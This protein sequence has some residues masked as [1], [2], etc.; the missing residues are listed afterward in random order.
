MRRLSTDA[1]LAACRLSARRA[2]LAVVYHRLAARTGDP[3]SELVPAHGTALV[4][5][6]L[7]LV[8]RHFKLV[9]ASELL[10]AA[11]RR[12]RGGRF[13]LA[14]TFDDDLRSHV[15][16]ARPLLTRIGAPATFFV[17]GASLDGPHTFWWER[18]QLA[19]DRGQAHDVTRL[20]ER[21][22]ARLASRPVLTIH[23][24]ALA[25]DHL[26]PQARD[27]F[28]DDLAELTGPASAAAGL[29]PG[30]L[31]AMSA[32]GFEIGFHTLRH[33][34][35]RT[36]DDAELAGALGE[37][38]GSVA[39]VAGGEPGAV[40]YPHGEADARVAEAAKAAGYAFG[41][42]TRPVAVEAG[43]DPLLLGRIVPSFASTAEF[44]RQLVRALRT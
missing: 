31:R 40:A 10:P 28:A 37:G 41:F 34:R 35:L 32:D 9:R 5:A 36:L 29:R 1:L 33:Y 16:L 19:F 20:A 38:R 17:C 25:V 26:P 30:D 43:A 44:A 12:R 13:P 2:G 22:R 4:E 11:Q 27:A 14:V 24:I 23:D 6:Q 21:R 39:A 18:M 7:R 42:T 8:K 15:E 3:G